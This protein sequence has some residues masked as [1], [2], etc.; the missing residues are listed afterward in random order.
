MIILRIKKRKIL[1][2]YDN[3]F[4]VPEGFT[5]LIDAIN[6]FMDYMGRRKV[7]A[8]PGREADTMK[9]FCKYVVQSSDNTLY[10]LDKLREAFYYAYDNA[11]ELYHLMQGGNYN[12][13]R[14]CYCNE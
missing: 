12:K 1:L 9:N 6:D 13:L 4:L 11:P 5:N 7:K 14:R 8:M 10:N 3:N 2:I